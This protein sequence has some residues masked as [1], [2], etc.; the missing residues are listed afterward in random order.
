MAENHP[1][2]D[3]CGS[4]FWVIITIIKLKP[5]NLIIKTITELYSIVVLYIFYD[6][7]LKK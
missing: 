1:M 7:S 2:D 6:S 4:K 3:F 5:F